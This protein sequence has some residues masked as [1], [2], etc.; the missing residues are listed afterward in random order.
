LFGAET[1]GA[2]HHSRAIPTCREAE[3]NDAEITELCSQIML[4]E[5]HEI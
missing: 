2:V 1:L 3:I 4:F 5:Q